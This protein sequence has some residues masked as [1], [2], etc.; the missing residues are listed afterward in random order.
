MSH[1]AH[2]ADWN[3][4]AQA[5]ALQA[6][7]LEPALRPVTEALLDAVHAAPGIRL[8]DLACGPG[9][10][11]AAARARGADA[12]GTDR[13][14]TM[15]AQA[16]RR[17]PDVAFTVGDMAQPP[18]GPWDAVT[19]RFAAHHAGSAWL[20]AAHRVLRGGG[21]LAVAEVAATPEA[22]AGKVDGAEWRRRLEA[23]GFEGVTVEHVAVDPPPLH[24]HE[25]RPWP[26]TWV[27]CGRKPEGA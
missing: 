8:L 9:H 16:R 24:G 10:T 26:D 18:P 12:H 25:A 14:P 11:T 4:Q 17:F 19:C 7:V 20:A 23:A 22:P 5:Y 27:V 15:V 2:D 6:D 13:S 1:D 3:A 21:R